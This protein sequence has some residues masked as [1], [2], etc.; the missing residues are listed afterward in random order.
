MHYAPSDK[1]YGRGREEEGR[2]GCDNVVLENRFINTDPSFQTLFVVNWLGGWLVSWPW[3][4]V[5][6]RPLLHLLVLC[7][8]MSFKKKKVSDWKR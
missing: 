4:D 2:E 8:L 6:I 3:I 1:T 5:L 7:Y